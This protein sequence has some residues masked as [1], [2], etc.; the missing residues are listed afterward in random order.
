MSDTPDEFANKAAVITGGG[1]GIGRATALRL[2]RSGANVVIASRSLQPL[3][4]TAALIAKE[5][6]RKALVLP[7]DV[8]NPDAVESLI[9]AT[10]EHFG[11]LDLVVNNAGG[12]HLKS[13]DELSVSD[14]ERVV[15]L[16]LTSAFLMIR[17]AVQHLERVGGSV[18]NV[19]SSS[20]SHGTIG[21]SAYSAAKSGLEML[22]KVAAAELTPRGIRVNCVAPGL[23]RSVGAEKAWERGGL[24]IEETESRLPLRRVGEPDDIARIITFL[25]SEAAGY[26][27][28]EIIHADGGPQMDGIELS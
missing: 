6:G 5:T 15:S 2:A 20:A 13:I 21:G 9:D 28:G 19:S 4:E 8:R 24:V 11:R 17:S 1:T 7:T 27:T 10:I 25:A 22:T 14:W 3:E 26:L 23:V 12:T 18:V 16:N